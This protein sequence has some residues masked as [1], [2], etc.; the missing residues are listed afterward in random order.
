MQRLGGDGVPGAV[1]AEILGELGVASIVLLTNN[2]EK[3]DALRADGVKV[4]ERLPVQVEPNEHNRDYLLTKRARMGHLLT[5]LG[6][7]FLDAE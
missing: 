2:P 4:N 3:V 6:E 1:A 7:H 5:H